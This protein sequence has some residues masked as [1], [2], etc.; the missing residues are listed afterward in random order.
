MVTNDS[1]IV[2]TDV[3]I[4]ID[5]PAVIQRPRIL[6]TTLTL[7]I[8]ILAMEMVILFRAICDS[9][10]HQSSPKFTTFIGAQLYPNDKVETK[11]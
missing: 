1:H 11:L 6:T 9:H 5:I 4:V 8:V 10:E 3:S 7:M 2:R